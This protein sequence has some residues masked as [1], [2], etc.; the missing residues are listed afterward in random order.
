MAAVLVLLAAWRWTKR[1]ATKEWLPTVAAPP[2]DGGTLGK[3]HEKRTED[4]AEDLGLE[5]R[6]P[7][8][9][10]TPYTAYTMPHCI[11]HGLSRQVMGARGCLGSLMALCHSTKA[12]RSARPCAAAVSQELEQRGALSGHLLDFR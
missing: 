6:G 5:S 10:L 8:K 9:V 11:S 2:K 1:R 7:S 12:G 3:P 4:S